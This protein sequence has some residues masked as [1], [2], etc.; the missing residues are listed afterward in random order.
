M[1]TIYLTLC[2]THSLS[3]SIKSECTARRE[4]NRPKKGFFGHKCPTGGHIVCKLL[5]TLPSVDTLLL[6][7]WRR[8]HCSRSRQISEKGNVFTFIW[9]VVVGSQFP[10]GWTQWDQNLFNPRP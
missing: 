3:L 4:Q 7:R 2:D 8:D 5:S 9:Q 6:T 1:N 10:N